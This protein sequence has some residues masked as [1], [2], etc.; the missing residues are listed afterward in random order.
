[1]STTISC[2][3]VP[4]CGMT[5]CNVVTCQCY[6]T[7]DV[8]DDI[9]LYVMAQGNPL[10]R[11]NPWPDRNT[12]YEDYDKPALSELRELLFAGMK[13]IHLKMATI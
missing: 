6:I 12:F 5:R 9:Y 4:V 8:R 13:R 10:S 7:I 3:N 11:D 2:G 1:M